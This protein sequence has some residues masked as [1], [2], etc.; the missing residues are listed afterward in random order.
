MVLTAVLMSVLVAM[1]AFSIDIGFIAVS[2]TEAHRTSDAAA[3]AAG[4]EM[5]DGLRRRD[6]ENTLAQ[7]VQSTA[8]QFSTSNVVCNRGPTLAVSQGNAD[9]TQGYM[10]SLA[11]NSPIVSDPNNPYRAVK[12]RVRKTEQANGQVPLY[13]AR[14][15]GLT[16]R[17][18]TVESTAALAVNIRGFNVPVGGTTGHDL[19]PFAIDQQTWDAMSRG[20]GTDQ[21]RWDATRQAVVAGSDGVREVNLYPQGTG[22]PGNRGTVDIGSRNNSTRDIARQIVSGI[23]ADDLVALGKPLCLESG[24]TMTLEG[25]TGI[26]AGVKDELA[27]I[28]GK[29]RIIPVF[30]RVDGNGNNAVYTIERWV[31]VRILS[32][33]LT[34]AMN[35]KQV[36]VQPTGVVARNVIPGDA[37]RVWSEGLYSPVVLVK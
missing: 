36:M 25:D 32:V 14:I 16:G 12:V 28:I 31:G 37:S 3:L 7:N 19:L 11:S 35:Q 4:W 26:S 17:D 2:R 33:R 10:S 29:T 13:F 22:S 30:S 21:F 27:S 6:S 24:G 18:L 23:S 9:I 34:G 20:V 5:V 8:Q 15:F 1:L